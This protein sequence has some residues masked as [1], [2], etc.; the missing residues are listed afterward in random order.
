MYPLQDQAGAPLT[1]GARKGAWAAEEDILL[2]RCIE[3]YGEGN[4]HQVPNRA[5]LNRCRKS[6]RLR[7]VNYLRPNI[8]RGRFSADEVDY[9][10]RL[11][12]LL[13]NRWALI[14]AR[15][16]G[17]TSNDIKNYWN[18]K[19]HKKYPNKQKN[20]RA[21]ST[22]QAAA[23]TVATTTE[24]IKPRPWTFV[25]TSPWLL[26]TRDSIPNLQTYTRKP[27]TIPQQ[28]QQPLMTLSLAEPR[29]SSGANTTWWEKLLELD[30][31][32]EKIDGNLNGPYPGLVSASE[33]ASG[34]TIGSHEAE[35]LVIEPTA[36][37]TDAEA[38]V[39]GLNGWE[40]FMN[41]WDVTL[42]P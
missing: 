11:H 22:K 18:T 9:I 14:A 1:F 35:D 37:S 33:S 19:L 21:K 39:E 13:G 38:L 36:L 26:Q 3:K 6:C 7:W 12:N 31:D 15:L 32:K 28:Q 30:E 8:N 42:G 23:T 16:P 25:K 17:R 34:L 4:W 40:D 10:V 20:S 5:G 27:S 41:F 29:N 24:I 2:R